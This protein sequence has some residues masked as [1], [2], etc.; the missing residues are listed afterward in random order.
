MS[1][2]MAAELSEMSMAD[3]ASITVGR[4]GRV[5][6]WNIIRRNGNLLVADWEVKIYHIYPEV[7]QCAD[8]LANMECNEST[9]DM[10]FD[11]PPREV[12]PVLSDDGS[13]VSF[14]IV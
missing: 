10:V 14:A 3:G 8:V 12:V 7:N 5:T 1:N 2:G 11:Q 6:G 4:E 13:G 9:R